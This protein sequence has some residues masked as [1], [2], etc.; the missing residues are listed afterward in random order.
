MK[1]QVDKIKEIVYMAVGEASMCWSETP[2]G[3]FDS[4]RACQ[5]A[6]RI[7][8]LIPIELNQVAEVEDG[9]R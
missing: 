3:T 4:T 7:L 2:N 8:G 1:D 5:I 9:T 6:E